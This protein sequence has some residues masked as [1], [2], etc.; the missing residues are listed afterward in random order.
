MNKNILF[1]VN[2]LGLGH[3]TRSLPLIE[4][5][6]KN[7]KVYIVSTGNALSFLKSEFKNNKNIDFY[8]F[9]GFPPL[10]RGSGINFYLYIFKDAFKAALSVKKEKN[11][12]N[13]LIKKHNIN[14]II[15]DCRYGFYDKDIPSFVLTHM[16][17]ILL[18]GPIKIFSKIVNFYNY[19]CLNKY[20]LVFILDFEDKRNL[21]GKLSHNKHAN[22]L[23]HKYIGI[24]SSYKKEKI[25]QDIDYYFII[26]GFLLDTKYTFVNSLIE[27]S[28]K[29]KGKKI[30]V[31]GDTTQMY[32]K[33]NKENNIEIYS[34][35][36][37]KLRNKLM[38]RAKI[39]I[40]RSGYT[41]V[42]DLAELDKKGLFAPTPKQTEQ[43]YLAKSLNEKGYF[44]S[45][46][47]EKDFDLAKLLGNI[48]RTKG[49]KPKW[50]TQESV[51][52]IAKIID[53]FKK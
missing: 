39:V 27:Q 2:S 37:G 38:N 1:A 21:S 43:E 33:V 10:L 6:A 34:Y 14:L 48:K 15:S 11:F 53:G 20:D 31:L 45:F 23:L 36:S 8:N 28:K 42:M 50:K 12:C 5:Y 19:R 7:N 9:E 18:S 3:A 13:E 49:F 41:T 47:S 35:A 51:R 44:S 29:L 4:H 52:K 46:N 30:F 32:H 16:V 40:S 24:L 25:K 22:K 17:D 26:S